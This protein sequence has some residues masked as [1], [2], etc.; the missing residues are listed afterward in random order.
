MALKNH[1][2]VRTV[3]CFKELNNALLSQKSIYFKPCHRVLPTKFLMQ[4][5]WRIPV[6]EYYMK[7]GYFIEVVPKTDKQSQRI[8][9]AVRY[10]YDQYEQSLNH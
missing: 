7:K 2:I 8:R 9:A 5:V 1:S 10:A 3:T 4:T 6:I